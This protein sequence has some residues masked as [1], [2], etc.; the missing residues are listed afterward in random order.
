MMMQEKIEAFTKSSLG[1]V[2]ICV[3]VIAVV[4]LVPFVAIWAVNTLAEIG[5]A[6][7]YIPHGVYSYFVMFVFVAMFRGK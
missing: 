2:G 7:F 1:V 6:T 4:C 3:A 5:G